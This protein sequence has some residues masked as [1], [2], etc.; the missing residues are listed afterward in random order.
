MKYACPA[1]KG[2]MDLHMRKNQYAP[3]NREIGANRF[4]LI[5]NR[6]ISEIL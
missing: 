4:R 3:P 5:V 2:E 1:K 6:P